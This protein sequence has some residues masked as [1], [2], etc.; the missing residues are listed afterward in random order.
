LNAATSLAPVMS[1]ST[2]TVT[3]LRSATAL[4]QEPNPHVLN[5]A[6]L[7]PLPSPPPSQDLGQLR[8]QAQLQGYTGD[9]CSNCNSMRMKVSGHCMVCEDCGTTTGCS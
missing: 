8:S 9:Q 4:K 2:S 7:N 1:T 3:A 5:A 6:E